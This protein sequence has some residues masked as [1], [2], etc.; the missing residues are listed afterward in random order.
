LK[1]NLPDAE[2]YAMDISVDALKVAKENAVINS[3]DIEFLLHDI[4]T[5]SLPRQV[6]DSRLTTHDFDII[7]SNPPYVLPSEK[8]SL[9]KNVLDFEPHEALFVPEND[10]LIFYKG[11]MDFAKKNLSDRGVIYFEVNRDYARNVEVEFH[12][13][14]FL[15]TETKKDLSGNE[16]MIRGS[17]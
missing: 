10:P 7:V 2:V 16:R 11:I 5:H 8:K 1:K 6:G 4:L 3:V 15:Q 12:R 17:L 9:H 14:G 13:S